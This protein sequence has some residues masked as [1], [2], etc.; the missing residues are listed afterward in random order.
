[1]IRGTIRDLEEAADL[2]SRC[3]LENSGIQQELEQM[4]QRIKSLAEEQMVMA[5]RKVAGV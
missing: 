3:E 4:I 1:M 2:L 5:V